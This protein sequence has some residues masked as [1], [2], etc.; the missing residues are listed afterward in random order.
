M[1]GRIPSRSWRSHWTRRPRTR[2]VLPPPHKGRGLPWGLRGLKSGRSQVPEQTAGRLAAPRQPEFLPQRWL[3]RSG[4]PRALAVPGPALLLLQKRPGARPVPPEPELREWAPGHLL[5][6]DS[7]PC[8]TLPCSCLNAPHLPWGL[9]TRPAQRPT[10]H[11]LGLGLRKLLRPLLPQ[12]PPGALGA[13]YHGPLSYPD[14]HQAQC[15][16]GRDKTCSYAVT[17]QLPKLAEEVPINTCSWN[18]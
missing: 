1:Q 18:E 3:H 11:L 2:A 10:F 17:P 7:P 12:R 8:P 9:C 15:P 5:S 14:P 13:G 6:S 16:W 4:S